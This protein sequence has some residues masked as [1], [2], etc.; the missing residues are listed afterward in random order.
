ML[1]VEGGSPADCMKLLRH[2]CG[3]AVN[4]AYRLYR[5]TRWRELFG[6]FSTP[7]STTY[8][9]M[10]YSRRYV[11]HLDDNYAQA[12][13]DEDFAETFAVWLAPGSEW[14]SRYAG[15]P[16]LPKLQYVD[17]LMR[18]IADQPP[19]VTARRRPPWA[20]SRKTSTLAAFYERKK[21]EMGTDFK[22]Y[23]DTS[24]RQVFAAPGPAGEGWVPAS[25]F[26]RRHRRRIVDSASRWSGHRKYD[27]HELMGKLAGR[28]DALDLQARMDDAVTLI[29]VSSLITTLAHSAWRIR[30]EGVHR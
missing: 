14:A 4:Y 20:A 24:L 30:G 5:R 17:R 28:C 21:V 22:G 7:Y 29:E 10:P 9:S 8:H 26:L 3:H 15:W 27:I 18:R 11:V 16:V 2:E 1:E 13:P 6:S 12:H 25:R 19:R 23:Y